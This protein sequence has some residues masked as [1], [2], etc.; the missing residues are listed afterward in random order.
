MGWKAYLVTLVHIGSA[1]PPP[2]RVFTTF[3]MPGVTYRELRHSDIP[4]AVRLYRKENWATSVE[5]VSSQIHHFGSGT[6]QAAYSK[7][8]ELIGEYRKDGGDERYFS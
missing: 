5:T 3:I 6:F 4:E 1:P 8:G 7:S 2:R